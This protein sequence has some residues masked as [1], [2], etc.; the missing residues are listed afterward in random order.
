MG[1]V[2]QSINFESRSSKS[3]L[4]EMKSDEKSAKI[5]ANK[6]NTASISNGNGAQRRQINQNQ[7]INNK[8]NTPLLDNIADQIESDHE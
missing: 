8:S 5:S 7:N 6:T 4:I 1:L 3:N 2:I